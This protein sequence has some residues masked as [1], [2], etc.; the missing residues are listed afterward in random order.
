MSYAAPR[1]ERDGGTGW[2]VE[3]LHRG[4]SIS[5]LW[6]TAR[7]MRIGAAV[8]RAGGI[9]GVGTDP[10]HRRRGLALRVLQRSL[11]MMADEGYE[12]SLLFG[13]E[14]FYHRAGFATCMAEHG[15]S[16][17]AADARR[18]VSPLKTRPMG[19]EDLPA[20][21]R[22]Y[23]TANAARTASVVRGRRWREFPMGSGFGVRGL[24]RVVHPA[25]SPRR[26]LGYFLY[27]DRPDRSRLAE[28]AGRGAEAHAA[29]LRFLARR[30]RALRLERITASV[31]VDHPF[32]LYCRGFGARD[33]TVYP[34]NAG[35][36]GRIID[37]QRFAAAMVPEWERRWPADGPGGIE[38]QTD[39]G[40][41][42]LRRRRDGRLQVTGRLPGG[43][44]RLRVSDQMALF[45][46]AMG[47]RGADDAAAAGLLRGSRAALAVARGLFPLRVAHMWWPD[48]F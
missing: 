9:A 33:E 37:L 24:A 29:V 10:A 18:A 38:L 3:I 35:P 34:R 42:A 26:L 39:L 27:D 17:A 43:G 45:Q 12:S 25:G 40:A 8:V 46:L 36:M 28:V 19:P 11:Q 23:A 7:R 48:R 14:D 1:V 15:L 41:V 22:L 2:K 31:P 6:I 13:I 16:L 32:A 30:A 44:S 20:V 47:Y 5:R 4:K 21:R